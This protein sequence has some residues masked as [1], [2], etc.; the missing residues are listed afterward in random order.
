MIFT[1]SGNSGD[2]IFSLPTINY[3]VG[4]KKEAIL[5]IKPARYVYGNQYDFLK[6][7]LLQQDCIKEVLPYYPPAPDDWNYFR[8]PGLKYDYDLDEA[9]HQRNRGRIHIVKRYFDAFGIVNQDHTKAWLK[10]DDE[11]PAKIKYALIHLTPRWNGLQYDWKKIYHEAIERHKEVFFIGLKSEHEDFCNRFG[12]IPW[13]PTET[14]LD[15]ARLIRDCAALYCNQTCG[16]AIAQGLGKE[17]Y[18]VKNGVKTNCHLFT[19]NEHLLGTEYLA[20]YNTLN[21][22]PDS[23]IIRER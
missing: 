15:M 13:M 20:S 2:V 6:D 19:S 8:W 3:L 23:H 4:G 1:H 17:Y 11:K 10:I 12:W 16:L 21:M 5:Y 22:P 9:R 14:M 18:L 7:F